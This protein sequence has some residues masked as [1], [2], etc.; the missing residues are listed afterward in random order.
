M[1][2]KRMLL[3][4]LFAS[5]LTACQAEK[6][7]QMVIPQAQLDVLHKAQG[8]ES[9]LLKARQQQESKIKALGL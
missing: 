8:L 4:V 3:L 2:K 7:Q 5:P 6:K 1:I 9:E